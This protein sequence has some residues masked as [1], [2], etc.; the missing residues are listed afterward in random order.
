MMGYT[1]DSF[2]LVRR[3]QIVPAI[4]VNGNILKSIAGLPVFLNEKQKCAC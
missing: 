3:V 4:I 1:I 2:T